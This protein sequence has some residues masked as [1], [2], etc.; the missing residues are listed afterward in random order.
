MCVRAKC[1]RSTIT[2]SKIQ[3]ILYP[4]GFVWTM[5]CT[6]IRLAHISTDYIPISW[7]KLLT[8]GFKVIK[9]LIW[10]RISQV[11]SQGHGVCV[12]VL[13]IEAR[14]IEM[15]LDK[16]TKIY[17]RNDSKRQQWK[18][19]EIANAFG[20][21]W[22]ECESHLIPVSFYQRLKWMC[23]EAYAGTFVMPFTCLNM[24]FTHR[25]HDTLTYRIV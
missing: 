15:I 17:S 6:C 24:C 18:F 2:L 8:R 22:R 14:F 3:Q 11:Y 9:I 1:Q 20:R 21:F 5:P 13:Y 4:A 19:A 25:T 16:M 10:F 7:Q 23:T 12:H